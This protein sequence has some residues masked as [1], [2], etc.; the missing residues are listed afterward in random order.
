MVT[1][2]LQVN[3]TR[4]ALTPYLHARSDTEHYA[5]GLKTATNVIVNRYGGFV[6]APGTLYGGEAKSQVL[7]DT[8]R[9]IPFRFNRSQVYAIE[10]G[11]LYF[12]FWIMGSTG[13]EQIESASV[14]V[15]VATPYET[16]DLENISI[17]QSGDVIYVFCD[18]F[19]PRTLT[20][21][22]ETVWTLATYD[23]IDGP[24]LPVNIT[25]TTLTPASTAHATPKMTSN[26]AP[27]GT[28]SMSGGTSSQAYRLFD[29]DLDQDTIIDSA[30]SGYVRYDF[31]AGN[32]VIIDAMALT[33]IER[34]DQIG[35]TPTAWR[36]RASQDA[37]TWTV[38]DTQQ[39]QTNWTGGEVRFF[40]FENRTAYRYYELTFTG[41]AG[42]GNNSRF[43]EIAYHL[44]VD[45]QTPF[46]L[47][48]SATTG[49]NGGSGF[50]ST[51]VGRAIRLFGSDGRWRWA[52]IAAVTNT[53]TVTIT[54]YGHALPD[55]SPILLW[56][57][58]A[59]SAQSG[60]PK[61]VAIYEDRLTAVGHDEDP[62]GVW[63][64][65][66]SDYD[67]FGTSDPLV[68]DDAVSVRLTG[69]EL[70]G[71][72]WMVTGRDILIGTDASLRALGRNDQS[73]A[74]GPS[75][76]RQRNETYVTT[77]SVP[78][79][80]IENMVIFADG[81]RTRLYEAAYTYE[82]EGYQA[83]ELSVLNEHLFQPG[84]KRLAYQSNPHRLIWALRDDGKL[85]CSTYDRAQKVYG[86]TL[87]DY[88]GFIED[89]LT[90]P[91]TTG[92]DMF[93]IVR[94]TVNG[95]TVRYIEG[96]AEFWREEFALLDTPVFSAC[97]LIYDG[98]STSSITNMDHLD[99]ET[100]G[101]WADGLDQGDAAVTSGNT[102]TLP[103]AAEQIVLG[104]RM[105]WS[106]ETLR[107]TQW[108]NQDGSGM[109]RLVTI[110]EAYID[111]YE[112]RGVS[113]RTQARD[114]ADLLRFEDDV[115]LTP[116]AAPPLKTGAFPMEVDDNWRN[117][118][119][120]VI[121]GDKMYPVSV[122]AIGLQVEGEP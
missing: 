40:E 118:G 104:L 85:A 81:D 91:G 65:R 36:V 68:A 17:Q 19:Q 108:G 114:T 29:R 52:K 115:T 47:V 25:S 8:T 13:P 37:S 58:G 110:A 7:A 103:L 48:A 88:G 22:S 75:N 55:T 10:A 119:Q 23:T 27:S 106:V 61:T 16:E 4:G 90:L 59:W 66:S 18:G 78:P 1:H 56:Q 9:F 62:T 79:L 92:D 26:T 117:N 96:L 2:P 6:R 30:A 74:F 53:T 60:W 89:I 5:A 42:D 63:S 105:E 11:D 69:G 72:N 109:G 94:R 98:A 95:S 50:Q 100:V 67:N 54:L 84:I 116:F 93:L 76:A 12:R 46:N 31:G 32:E 112:A 87:V 101:I 80:L 14:P 82:T 3:M 121:E 107:L 41:G 35:D 120:L 45:S 111:L 71:A 99:S 70:N 64:S 21:T 49:I 38:L 83:Q 15:E 20:R 24:Y 28:A 34:Q 51:D 43:A 86:A 33:A 77:S 57:L 73:Q 122:R 44:S 113:V 39:G 97:S 102:V